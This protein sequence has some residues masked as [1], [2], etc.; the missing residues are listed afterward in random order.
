MIHT[1][2]KKLQPLYTT[3]K[4]KLGIKTVEEATKIKS[5]VTYTNTRR[6]NRK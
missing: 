6:K 4:E 3:L 1:I 5:K 2:I